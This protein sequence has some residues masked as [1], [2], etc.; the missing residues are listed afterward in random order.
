M[1]R[2]LH[3]LPGLLAALFLVTLAVTGAVLALAPAMDRAAAVI[4]AAGEVSVAQLAGRVVEH[5][6][7]TEQIVRGLSGE[8][9]VYYNQDGQPGA[10]LVDPMTGESIAPYEPSAFFTWIRD[11]HRSFLLDD[12]G[13]MLAGVMA[14]VMLLLCVSGILLLVR[15]SGGWSALFRPLAGSGV[16]RIHA[17][18][19][20]Y[21]VLGIIRPKK[22]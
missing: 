18:L 22:T 11:L 16:K 20:R 13:R 1:L 6:P 21:G 12:A 19:A 8:V 2:K 10:D 9:I 7:G 15:R 4:P 17:E 5:Y 14:A 3:G